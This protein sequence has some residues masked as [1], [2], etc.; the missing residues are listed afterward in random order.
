V[1][2]RDKKVGEWEAIAD[3]GYLRTAG[4][5]AINNSLTAMMNGLGKRTLNAPEGDRYIDR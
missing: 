5:M 1:L 2:Q 3:G 4:C